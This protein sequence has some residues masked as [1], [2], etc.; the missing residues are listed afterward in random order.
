MKDKLYFKPPT[1][2][3]YDGSRFKKNQ[4][5]LDEV[6]QM[7]QINNMT[8]DQILQKA[9]DKYGA[10]RQIDK[11]IE[12]MAELTQALLK[13]RYRNYTEILMSKTVTEDDFFKAVKSEIADVKITI[14]QMEMLFGSCLEEENFKINRL[15][16]R[17]GL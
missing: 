16:K 3:S 14:K 4:L 13:C 7:P 15:K 10:D 9:I 12:E 5:Y 2:E 6:G 17:L 1:K 11:C 8:N